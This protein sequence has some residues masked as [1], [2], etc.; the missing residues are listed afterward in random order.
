MDIGFVVYDGLSGTSGG[1]RYDRK[2]VS[3]LRAQ[4][5]T[6]RL[7][8]LPHRSY[9]RCLADGWSRS[10][11]RQLNQPVDVL[12]Q[13]ELCH[14]SLWGQN[15]HLTEPE[16][17]V[18]LVHLVRSAD[19]TATQTGVGK[20]LTSTVERRYLRSV[21]GIVATSRHTERQARA[22]AP[23]VDSTVAYPGG[24]REQVATEPAV[25]TDPERPLRVL[26][27][28]TFEPRKGV[29]I[30]L[31][32]LSTLEGN[33][34]ATLVGTH[35]ANPRYAKRMRTRAQ[36]LGERVSVHG[37]LTDAELTSMFTW[38]DVLA[39]PSR[40]E[41]F[42]MVYLEAMEHGVVPI[43][44]TAG[45]AGEFVVDGT[46]GLLVPP[47]TAALQAAFERIESDRQYLDT[48]ARG[49]LATANAHPNW[50]ASL[51]TVRAFLRSQH[52]HSE[53]SQSHGMHSELPQ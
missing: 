27:V 37:Q 25:T 2:L 4:G 13:D 15:R 35:D 39:V 21:D 51:A 6:V 43:A 34:R 36:R 1:Y 31:D 9:S 40:Y 48:L 3:Y 29:D 30:L 5:D 20:R 53:S 11:R 44:S 8:S 14:P 46:N 47:D 23:T 22:L 33:W 26:F 50:E 52:T 12:L 41:G 17:V 28:G 7:I 45:G 24:R 19:P 10:V 16:T 38:A 32:S 42:G 18:S 49:A